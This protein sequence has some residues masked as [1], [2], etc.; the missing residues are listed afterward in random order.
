MKLRRRRSEDRHQS[1]TLYYYCPEYAPVPPP[2]R[3]VLETGPGHSSTQS[4]A[5][6]AGRHCG[7][8]R[9]EVRP[10]VGVEGADVVGAIHV[11][12]WMYVSLVLFRLLVCVCA[13]EREGERAR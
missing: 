4:P 8:L 12:G 3:E 9:R 7:V 13:Y 6:T 2:K 5:H 1:Y 11:S 10:T